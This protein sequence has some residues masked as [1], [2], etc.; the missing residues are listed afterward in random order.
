MTLYG[1]D[2]GIKKVE[3][4]SAHASELIWSEIDGLEVRS[5]SISSVASCILYLKRSKGSNMNVG[6]IDPGQAVYAQDEVCRLFAE[7]ES[8][9]RNGTRQSLGLEFGY[10]SGADLDRAAGPS[11]SSGKLASLARCCHETS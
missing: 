8:G 7:V 6:A 1:W 3:T 11:S 4:R 5:N 2:G 9:G 10:L